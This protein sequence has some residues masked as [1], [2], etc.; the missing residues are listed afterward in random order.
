MYEIIKNLSEPLYSALL[1]VILPSRVDRGEAL[2]AVCAYAQKKKK[3]KLEKNKT[4]KCAIHLCQSCHSNP[5]RTL[6]RD[7]DVTKRWRSVLVISVH[8]FQATA[9]D[10]SMQN[11][12]VLPDDKYES[13]LNLINHLYRCIYLLP[14]AQF[15]NTPHHIRPFPVKKII[16]QCLEWSTKVLFLLVLLY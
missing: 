15:S 9:P 10:K 16:W 7:S 3:H 11:V 13:V 8:V 4:H 2:R 12:L 5:C 1:S 6:A 14:S